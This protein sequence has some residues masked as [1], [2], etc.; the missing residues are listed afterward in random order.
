MA[1]KKKGIFRKTIGKIR[2][3]IAPTFSEQFSKAKEGGKK[4]FRSTRA[5]DKGEGWFGKKRGKLDYHTRTKAEEAKAE[6]NIPLEK[7]HDRATKV[8]SCLTEALNLN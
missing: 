8:N 6:K 3:K 7:E 2:K 5:K 4:T 1:E